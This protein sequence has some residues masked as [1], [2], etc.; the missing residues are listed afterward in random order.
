ME[1][2]E[3]DPFDEPLDYDIFHETSEQ[4][5]EEEKKD[6]EDHYKP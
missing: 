1:E 4:Y 6:E 3:E 2:L 5:Y